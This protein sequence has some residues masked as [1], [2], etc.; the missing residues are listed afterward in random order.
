MST[1]KKR[2]LCVCSAGNSRSVALA[3]V[4]KD[5]YGQDA[6]A[7][8]VHKAS[9]GTQRMLY[10][11]ADHVIVT[12][13]EAMPMIP[14]QWMHKVVVCD[15]GADRYFRGFDQGLMETYVRFL[16]QGKLLPEDPK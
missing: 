1:P 12:T 9:E 8:G 15:V 2:F 10:N 14:Q 5:G 16:K 6:L 4:L 3:Y 7:M 13:M 11:W